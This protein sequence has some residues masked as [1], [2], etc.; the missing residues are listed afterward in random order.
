M[1]RRED[2]TVTAILI[3]R[4]GVLWIG[5][6]NGLYR[7]DPDGSARTFTLA[8]GLPND[9]IMALIEDR[10]GAVWVGTRRG[11][12]RRDAAAG[13]W[14]VDGTRDGLPAPRV[15]SLLETSDGTVWV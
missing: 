6:S 3:D 12:V 1:P 4:R 13:G 8:D 10:A 15:E 14:H 5:L 2:A 7:R 9:Y 11:L